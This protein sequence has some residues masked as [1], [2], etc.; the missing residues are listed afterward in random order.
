MPAKTR[1]QIDNESDIIIQGIRASH[2]GRQEISHKDKLKARLDKI[3]K[4]KE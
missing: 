1:E 2:F 3:T 4:V